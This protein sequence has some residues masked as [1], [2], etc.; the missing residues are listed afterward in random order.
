MTSPLVVNQ[1]KSSYRISRH[2]KN[3]FTGLPQANLENDVND[4]IS[5]FS[6]SFFIF[7][8]EQWSLWCTQ[9]DICTFLF[10]HRMVHIKFILR[11]TA[12]IH[13]RILKNLCFGPFIKSR[14]W[15]I[16]TLMQSVKSR[17]MFLQAW[18][19]C[20]PSMAAHCS[21]VHA[22]S[23]PFA[24]ILTNVFFINGYVLFCLL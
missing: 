16:K 9:T 1:P 24:F 7:F 14:A 6:L 18:N 20:R 21:V 2:L 11:W 22:P 10:F 23:F 4:Y 5:F 8:Q 12:L 13:P 15:P 17:G 19:T 3:S